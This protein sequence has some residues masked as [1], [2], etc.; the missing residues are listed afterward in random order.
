MGGLLQEGEFL[1]PVVH[2]EADFL[3][4]IVAGDV[5]DIQMR[6][7]RLGTKSFTLGFQLF[8][9]GV[10]VGKATLVHVTVERK[11]FTSIPL[12]ERLRALLQSQE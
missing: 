3:A 12:P 9:E 8:K 7:L 2:A 1:I 6:V 10:E 11:T 5:L 4:P